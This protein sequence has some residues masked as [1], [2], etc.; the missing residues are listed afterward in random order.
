LSDFHYNL[1]V[2]V[3]LIRL[4]IL[5]LLLSINLKLILI[6]LSRLF[7]DLSSDGWLNLEDHMLKDD[8]LSLEGLI[9]VRRAHRLAW[10]TWN[11]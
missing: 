4:I 9:F 3:V 7:Y 10:L 2:L 6:L 8:V 5:I 1:L 11:Q